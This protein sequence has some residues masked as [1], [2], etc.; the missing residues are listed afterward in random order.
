MRQ[1]RLME[2]S[3]A[4][5]AAVFGGS[6]PVDPVVAIVPTDYPN[7]AHNVPSGSDDGARTSAGISLTG[8]G[9]SDGGGAVLSAGSVLA[10]TLRSRR[11]SATG[12]DQSCGWSSNAGMSLWWR[13]NA[14]GLGGFMIRGRFGLSQWVAGHQAFVGVRALASDIGNTDPRDLVDAIGVGLDPGDT[15]W[16]VF[17]N[18]GSGQCTKLP[19]GA[20]FDVNTAHALEITIIAPQNGATVSWV[21][22]NLETGL[23]RAGVISTNLPSSTTFLSPHLWANTGSVVGPAATAARIDLIDWTIGSAAPAMDTSGELGLSAWDNVLANL[24]AGGAAG[25]RANL[26]IPMTIVNGAGGLS[27]PVPTSTSLYTSLART[28]AVST[29]G[30]GN[31]AQA[32]AGASQHFIG[33]A[34]NRGGFAW[35]MVFAWEQWVAGFRSFVGLRALSSD[36]GAAEPDALVNIIGIG[37]RS[38]QTRWRILHNDASGTA[39]SIDPG[40][41]FNVVNADVLELRIV[42]LANAATVAVRLRNL[43]TG[44]VDSRT[45]ATD[46]PA[47]TVFVGPHCQT[48]TGAIATPAS[49]I[50]IM[51][52]RV[53]SPSPLLAA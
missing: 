1:R 23:Q 48:N 51:D 21:V 44:A 8:T 7:E 53:Q 30:A 42:C 22:R 10:S 5:R 46:L 47:N 4:Y 29:V 11:L 26:G 6:G 25:T 40:A 41:S 12:V 37:V 32:R 20:A 38:D 18:D 13:G 17:H 2:Q 28:R 52:W 50:S 31:S 39:T 15:Q 19:L 9:T 34:A 14:A 27:Q 36:I 45:L 43:T 16:S 35:R 49:I 3:I 24:P 33:N